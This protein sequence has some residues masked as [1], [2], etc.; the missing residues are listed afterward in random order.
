MIQPRAEPAYRPDSRHRPA[1]LW[2]RRRPDTPA[3]GPA[4]LRL[5]CVKFT[6]AGQITF[7][8]RLEAEMADAL[9]IRFE[10]EDTGIGIEKPRA[11]HAFEQAD[12]RPPANTAAPGWGWPSPASWPS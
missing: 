1:A 4:Q 10:V 6:E 8:V 12:S 11:V 2:R 3:A 7:R 5:Q 9:L